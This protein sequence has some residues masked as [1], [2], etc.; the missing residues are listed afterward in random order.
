MI[1]HRF[2]SLLYK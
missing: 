1:D 2:I